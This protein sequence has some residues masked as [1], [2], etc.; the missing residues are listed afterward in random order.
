MVVFR[1]VKRPW[2]DY[3]REDQSLDK[4]KDFQKRERAVAL[5]YNPKISTAP[6]VTAQGVGLIATKIIA[7]ALKNNIPIKEDP[8]LVQI[9]ASLELNQEIP[10]SVY[11]V[12]AEV[13]A[14]VYS[15]NQKYRTSNTH[16]AF[17]RPSIGI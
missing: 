14:F 9:L 8:D 17:S 11:K 6:R 5:E 2:T 3:L 16:S 7:L 13:L 12:V 1:G 4:K 10:S 15:L